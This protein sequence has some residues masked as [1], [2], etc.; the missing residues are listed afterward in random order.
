[1]NDSD[2][3]EPIREI[4]KELFDES[5][6]RLDAATLSRLNQGRQRAL[7][8]L[9]RS[10]DKARWSRWVPVTGVAAAAVL[11]VMVVRG[12]VAVDVID[13]PVSASDF[14]MLIEAESLEMFENLEFY[15][16]LEELDLEVGAD[17]G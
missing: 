6:E 1:M 8:E 2:N 11:A 17:V 10:T 16:L 9:A 14:E 13:G 3:R 15:S 5:V 12:P 7:N 4:A